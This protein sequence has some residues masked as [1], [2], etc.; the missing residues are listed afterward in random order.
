MPRTSISAA[1]A[2]RRVHAPPRAKRATNASQSRQGKASTPAPG[3]PAPPRGDDWQ[4]RL[5]RTRQVEVQLYDSIN[6]AIANGD[7]VTLSRLQSAR[8]AALKEIRLC[9]QKATEAQLD[10]G[11]VVTVEHVKKMFV[12]LL[13]PLRE[14]LDKLPLNERTNCNPEHPEI[15][16]KA[17]SEWR[18]R[19]LER[20]RKAENPF[21]REEQISA[22]ITSENG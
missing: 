16:E 9:E 6:E 10:S 5:E 11:I 17:L 15:A 21:P 18:V 3:H 4:S 14:A 13:V 20:C 19:T 7:V 8:A 2:W 1:E 22:P 12:A